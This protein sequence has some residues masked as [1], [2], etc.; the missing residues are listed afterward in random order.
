MN[1]SSSVVF[2]SKAKIGEFLVKTFLKK[3]GKELSASIQKH[4]G[5]VDIEW[6]S[7]DVAKKET[8]MFLHGFSARK[9]NFL[10]CSKA[11]IG[12]FNIIIPDLPGFGK[13]TV[14]YDLVYNLENYGRW[15]GDFIES[16]RFEKF[17]L[18]GSSMGGAI[19]LLL[20]VK[21]PEKIMF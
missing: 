16:N 20:S 17:H 7:I 19:A 21:Y 18:V 15:L 12:N 13:S 8:V 3:M 6:I 11:L 4:T 14:N 10:I 2:K 9:E 1:S 5:E